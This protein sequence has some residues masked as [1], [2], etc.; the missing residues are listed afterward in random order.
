MLKHM[1]KTMAFLL[2][3]TLAFGLIGC[4]S[5]TNGKRII[6]ISHSQSQTHP[7]HLGLVAFE[8]YVESRLGDKYDV[9]IFPNELLGPTVKAIELVQ[10]GAIDYVVASTGNL[11]TFD[12]VYQIFSM[13]YLFD[14]VDSYHRVMENSELMSGIYKST[15]EAG[16]EAVTWFEAGTRN[17]YA[18]TPIK[19]PDD[20]KGKKIRVQQSPT[21]VRMMKLFG[22]AAA[23]M[24]FGEVYTAIQSG[25]I[26]GG[27]NNELALT[28]NKHGEVAKFYTYNQ[29][30]MVPDLLVG[31]VK[32][33]NGLSPEDRVI[34]DAAAQECTKVE[35]SQWDV[36][37]LDAIEQSKAMGVEFIKPDVEL[38]KAKVLPLQKELLL[39]NQKLQPIYDKIQQVNKQVK[40]IK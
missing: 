8:K 23:P 33:L 24:S 38:F 34:F 7:D 16:F 18:T 39:K 17:F 35:R 25:V 4:S 37:I 6:R 20:L 40:E 13:P 30:Q 32:F 9:Q 14:N 27:E 31:N 1:K 2:C 29:H 21:N 36:Q 22:A 12:N 3:S 26:N 28:N 19:T 5:V 15:A 10:T 11:E